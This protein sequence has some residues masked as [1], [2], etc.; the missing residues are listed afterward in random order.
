MEEEKL[1]WWHDSNRAKTVS[2][3]E[4]GCLGSPFH[5]TLSDSTEIRKDSPLYRRK[6]V[7]YQEAKSLFKL[8]FNG[9]S[10]GYFMNGGLVRGVYPDNPENLNSD[11][12]ERSMMEYISAPTLQEVKDWLLNVQKAVQKILS[13]H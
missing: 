12:C 8:G 13:T 3:V 5:S 6:F 7:P 10:S 1:S 4:T 11:F 9:K 2:G